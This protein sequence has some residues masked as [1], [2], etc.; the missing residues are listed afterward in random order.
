VSWAGNDPQRVRNA[1]R[2][3][4]PVFSVNTEEEAQAAI[5]RYCIHRYDGSCRWTDWP[6]DLAEEDDP[7]MERAFQEL[8]KVTDELRGWWDDRQTGPIK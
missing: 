6:H 4:L 7:H 8:D 2:S 3:S 1:T 5:V